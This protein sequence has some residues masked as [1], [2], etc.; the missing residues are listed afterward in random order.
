MPQLKTV[1]W[2]D[3]PGQVVARQGRRSQRFRLSPRFSRAI[4]R[5]SNRLRKQGD[6]PLFEPWHSVDEPFAGAV[7]ESA[8]ALVARLERDYDDLRLDALVRNSGRE[9]QVSTEQP[10]V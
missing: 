3:I 6:D 1:F 7:V 4:E 10:E 5:A 8:R 9:P 2:L